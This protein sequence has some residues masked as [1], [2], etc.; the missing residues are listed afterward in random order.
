MTVISQREFARRVGV[1]EATIRKGIDAG[2]IINGRTTRPSGTP[3][4][5]YETAL[6]EWNN[7]PG[8]LQA[9]AKGNKLAAP[10]ADKK[11]AAEVPQKETTT[12][13]TAAPAVNKDVFFDPEILAKKRKILSEKEQSSTISRQRQ[14]LALQKELGLLVSKD[15]VDSAL[16]EFGKSVRE[17]L[18]VLP[19]RLTA[20]IRSA[21]SDQEGQRIFYDGLVSMLKILTNP[22]DLSAE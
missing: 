2:W 8:G 6:Q 21:P 15:K 4:I 1:S 12:N 14:Q 3:A 22:P 18:L 11:P 9:A 5:D 17:N 7:S 19:N 10:G 13:A 16:F 20:L